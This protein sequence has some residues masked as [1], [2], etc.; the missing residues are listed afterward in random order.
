MNNFI[1]ILY[2]TMNLELLDPFGLVG[3][4]IKKPIETV[5]DIVTLKATKSQVD[6]IDA[7]MVDLII[8]AYKSPQNRQ[9][10]LLGYKYQP[11]IA[12]TEFAVYTGGRNNLLVIAFKGTNNT[13]NI[14][15]DVLLTLNVTPNT[16]DKSLLQFDL[17]LNQF[18]GTGL[19]PFLTGHS[20]GGTKVL[21]IAKSKAVAGTVFNPYIATNS[22]VFTTLVRTPLITKYII[23]G[24]IASN[25]ILRFQQRGN[26]EILVL[27]KTLA[28]PFERHSI[29]TFQ[30]PGNFKS[31]ETE[32]DEEE[33]IKVPPANQPNNP[34][35]PHKLGLR[36]KGEKHQIMFE[37]KFGLKRAEYC[38]PGTQVAKRIR[39]GIQPLNATDAVCQKH[40]IDYHRITV[41][42][43]SDEAKGIEVRKADLL[44]I[45]RLEPLSGMNASIPRTAIKAKMKAEDFGLLKRTAFVK[46]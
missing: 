8:E 36:F 26:V 19:Q 34:K 17:I 9:R 6:G 20:L 14:F 44:M 5:I 33:D 40:D 22:G 32:T 27:N 42:K 12:N 18:A 13:R 41:S 23:S 29:G 28:T 39:L 10:E 2:N 4:V 21:N 35:F 3:K 25:P 16:F 24:D 38:G 45:K 30:F 46:F 43:A 11:F 1:L 37:T 7:D 15:D 31:V